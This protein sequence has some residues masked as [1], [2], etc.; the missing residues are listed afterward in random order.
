ME[1]VQSIFPVL[2]VECKIHIA[3]TLLKKYDV[4]YKSM[5]SASNPAD[6]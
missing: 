5:D 1:V 3:N 4:V 6:T 2:S